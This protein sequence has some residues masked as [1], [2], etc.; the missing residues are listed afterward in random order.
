MDILNDVF[1]IRYWTSLDVYSPAILLLSPEMSEH[2]SFTLWKFTKDVKFVIYPIPKSVYKILRE[3]QMQFFD[4]FSVDFQK[5]VYQRYVHDYVMK[6]YFN[7]KE[8][9]ID[10]TSPIMCM[11]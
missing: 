2:M 11:I 4:K 6:Y 1:D 9:N 10:T 8:N 7:L 5:T 3:N